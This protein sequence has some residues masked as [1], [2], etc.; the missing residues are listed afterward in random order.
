MK[1]SSRWPPYLLPPEPEPCVGFAET[2]RQAQTGRLRDDLAPVPIDDLTGRRGIGQEDRHAVLLLD[3]DDVPETPDRLPRIGPPR[4]PLGAEVDRERDDRDAKSHGRV[5]RGQSVRS[6][7]T[8]D[9]ARPHLRG[10]PG[11]TCGVRKGSV[12]LMSTPSMIT[13]PGRDAIRSS[14]RSSSH[15]RITFAS[16]PVRRSQSPLPTPPKTTSNESP[17]VRV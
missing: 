6:A 9:M 12:T 1:G 14:D 5:S 8:S 17:T 2:G 4:P 16:S 3:G 11:G 15:R 13:F 10:P 7:W